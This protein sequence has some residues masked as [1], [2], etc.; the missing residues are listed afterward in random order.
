MSKLAH[1]DERSMAYIEIANL[2]S[3]GDIWEIVNIIERLEATEYEL[4]DALKAVRKLP[5]EIDGC[6]D[7]QESGVAYIDD[8]QWNEACDYMDSALAFKPKGVA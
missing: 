6:N 4:R 5:M 8:D 1:S 2:V 7:P 3:D